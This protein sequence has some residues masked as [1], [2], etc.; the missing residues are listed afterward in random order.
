MTVGTRDGLEQAAVVEGGG[1]EQDAP[2]SGAGGIYRG[3]R[4]GV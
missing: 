2:Q 4:C 3:L 1:G